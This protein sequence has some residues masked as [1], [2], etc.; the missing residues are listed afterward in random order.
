VPT[1]L[2]DD[3]RRELAY[4]DLAAKMRWFGHLTVFLVGNATL[5]IA[6]IL[7]G[8]GY[9]WFAWA[10]GV[11]FVALLTHMYFAFFR[12]KRPRSDDGST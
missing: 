1:P 3:E 9:P 2:T 5:V 4:K 7:I 6:W 12:K 11:W 8:R 10:T